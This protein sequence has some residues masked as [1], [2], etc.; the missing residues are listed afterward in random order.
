M[1]FLTS[2]L[3]RRRA[4]LVAGPIATA[5]AVQVMLVGTGI[6]SARI[7]GAE[8]RGWM[9]LLVLFP[10]VLAYLLG[11]VLPVTVTFVVARSNGFPASFLRGVLRIAAVMIG[12]IL[13][14]HVAVLAVW[15]PSAP[16][17]L[18]APALVSLAIGPLLLL[19]EVALASLQGARHYGRYQLVRLI[20]AA[21]AVAAIGTL[22]V[23]GAGTL[24]TVTS[25]WVLAQ[26]M[27]TG[28]AVVF[29]HGI[30]T[31]TTGTDMSW[32]QMLGFGARALPASVS[33]I[34]TL[35]LDHALVGLL[36]SPVSLGLYVVAQAF[37]NLPRLFAQAIGMIAYPETASATTVS[38][39]RRMGVRY[40][41]IAVI[42]LVT[43][44]V[45]LVLAIPVLI[46]ILFGREFEG[47]IG[48]AQILILAALPSGVRRVFTDV[49]QG[50]GRPGAG[51]LGEIV[52]WVVFPLAVLALLPPFGLAG[53]AWGVVIA[54]LVSMT[55]VAGALWRVRSVRFDTDAALDPDVAGESP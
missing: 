13:V 12:L 26:V 27:A 50:A 22:S 23:I 18:V 15:L 39:V 19:Q 36:L 30:P 24:A 40:G 32:R 33:P 3:A 45:A 14:A 17:K 55:A 52:S 21:L 41:A 51:A 11:M 48:I 20:L 10:V 42:V 43:S 1:R 25:A 44:I 8:D 6:L 35:R 2:L 31:T 53:V 4:P 16:P 9:A 46:P 29:V 47:S 28:L 54:G 49:L 5:A 7:L 34:E 37:T 38:E